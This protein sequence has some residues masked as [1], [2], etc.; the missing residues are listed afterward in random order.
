M[1][2]T[3]NIKQVIFTLSNTKELYLD[4]FVFAS[5]VE[6]SN[7]AETVRSGAANLVFGA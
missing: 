7:N 4:S 5:T 6:A 3:G 2:I 1:D